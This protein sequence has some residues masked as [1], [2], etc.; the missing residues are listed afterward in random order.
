[1]L[2]LNEKLHVVDN[3]VVNMLININILD[4]K[5]MN[6]S[7]NNKTL[8]IDICD[9]INIFISI[10][11]KNKSIQTLIFSKS[12]I[13][14]SVYTVLAVNVVDIDFRLKLSNNKNFFFESNSLNNLKIYVYIVDIDIKN[15]LIQNNSSMS[16][17]LF[18]RMNLNQITEYDTSAYIVINA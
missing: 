9:N 16:V 18:K 2:T 14:V 8:I 6:I 15:V 17:T 3:L 12:L 13:T 7:I 11:V 1:M 4:L 5:Q 10:N